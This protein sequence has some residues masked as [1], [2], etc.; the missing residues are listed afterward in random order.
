[1]FQLIS[2]GIKRHTLIKQ[3]NSALEQKVW[4]ILH[5]WQKYTKML[6][7]KKELAIKIIWSSKN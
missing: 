2:N 5:K 6:Y 3:K 4:L 7:F 1:M